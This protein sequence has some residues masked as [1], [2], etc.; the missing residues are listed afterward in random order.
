MKNISNIIIA[1]I[2]ALGISGAGYFASNTLY[3]SKI[4][5]NTAQVK[6]LAERKVQANRTNW[7]IGFSSSSNF[8][9]FSSIYKN[10]EKS[11][12]I[13]IEHL[14]KQGI[15]DAEIAIEAFSTNKKEYRNN[16]GEITGIKRTVSGEIVVSSDDIHKIQKAH[17]SLNKLIEKGISVTN[18]KPR[19]LFT[20]LN[21][22]KPEMLK[23]ATENA[24]IAANEFAENAG[25][26]V[27]RIKSARQGGFNIVDEGQ[28]YGDDKEI[29][30]NVRVVT[31]ITFYLND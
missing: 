13:I 24:R 25:T 11:Q 20:E 26:S 3:K 5:I 31:T 18:N 9:E 4:A 7:R 28:N 19:F 6:G 23:E 14:K 30:K 21:K 10:T 8:E 12:S 2:I 27:G 16:K 15:D 22:I 17:I 29:S 1:L